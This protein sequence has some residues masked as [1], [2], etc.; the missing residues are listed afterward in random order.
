[1]TRYSKGAELIE[2]PDSLKDRVRDDLDGLT[3]EE[4]LERSDAIVAGTMRQWQAGALVEVSV[5]I[6]LA[7]SIRADSQM[8]RVS[9]CLFT[10]IAQD[11]EAQAEA[12]GY[13]GIRAAAANL[14]G[15]LSRVDLDGDGGDDGSLRGLVEALTACLAMLRMQVS[16]GRRMIPDGR[17]L[18]MA[19]A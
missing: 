18:L 12:Y 16:E 10:S 3:L 13:P 14:L 6:R 11:M 8:S 15:I 9:L 2:R 1:M 4:I 7:A 19:A 5:M 17:D